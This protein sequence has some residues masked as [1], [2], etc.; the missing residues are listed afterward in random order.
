MGHFG[1]KPIR[2]AWYGLAWPALILN[3]F[4]QGALVM[5]DATM[6]ENPFYLLAP[7]DLLVPLV[8]LATMATVIASQATISGAYSLTQQATRLG[9]L[10][11]IRVQHTSDSER[12]QIYIAS[13]N[14]L[15][16]IGVL[17]LVLGFA[18]STALAAAYGI[19]VSGTMIITSVLSC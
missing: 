1:A 5:R 16:L 19:A 14:W 9:Y 11:R 8:I 12:G 6:A 18:S 13:V 3:Y 10:P 7:N 17:L 4:G 2:L 15:M